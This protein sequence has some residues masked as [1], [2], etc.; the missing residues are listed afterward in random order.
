M[1]TKAESEISEGCKSELIQLM[2]QGGRG[3]ITLEL[4]AVWSKYIRR[5]N[6][7]PLIREKAEKWRIL[8]FDRNNGKPYS[9]YKEKY[10]QFSVWNNRFGNS[11]D[12]SQVLKIVVNASIKPTSIDKEVPVI[13]IPEAKAPEEPRLNVK[14]KS[15]ENIK[16][17]K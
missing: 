5:R 17:R 1:G 2:E 9:K 12:M 7:T 11:K 16:N 8:Y 13:E 6:G 4:M 10:K 14:I 15:P 3:K